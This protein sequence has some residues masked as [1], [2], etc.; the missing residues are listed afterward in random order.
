MVLGCTECEGAAWRDSRFE[1]YEVA[2]A[3]C[4]DRKVLKLTAGEA[5]ELV[6]Q[7]KRD[8]K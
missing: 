8:V 7:W 3:E 2:A 1:A 6:D 5:R 4:G